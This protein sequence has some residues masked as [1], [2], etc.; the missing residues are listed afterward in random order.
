MRLSLFRIWLLPVVFVLAMG[1]SKDVPSDFF[2][3]DES[4]LHLEIG[5]NLSPLRSDP[6]D[7]MQKILS[8]SIAFFDANTGK[9]EFLKELSP[10]ELPSVTV[11]IPKGRYKVVAIANPVPKYEAMLTLGS[12]L[13]ALT[14]EPMSGVTVDKLAYTDKKDISRLL[15]IPMLNDQG[16][17]EVLP[18]QFVQTREGTGEQTVNIRLEPV[19]ARVVVYGKPQI[20]GGS[21]KEDGSEYRSC[22]MISGLYKKIYP[23]RMPDKL[24]GGETKEEAGDQ[25]DPQRRYARCPGFD[26]GSMEGAPLSD[27]FGFIPTESMAKG[28]Y[29]PDVQPDLS[30][31]FDLSLLA[32]SRESTMKPDA[33]FRGG[34]PFALIRYHYLPASLSFTPGGDY[35]W[36]GFGSRCMLLSEFKS[37]VEKVEKGKSIP[38]PGLAEAIRKV[39][40]SREFDYTCAF[41]QEG[42]RYYHKAANYYLVYIRHFGDEQAP[43]KRSYGRYGIVRNNEYRIKVNKIS[44]PGMAVVPNLAGN[45]S[46]LDEGSFVGMKMTVNAT[47]IREQEVSF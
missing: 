10:A 42:I 35:S 1:C 22:Y 21:I 20:E 19:L 46:R 38:V 8:L 18:E 7:P 28:L 4:Y 40:A 34:T 45:A 36:V 23:M 33:Y 9:L 12:P 47:N 13:S 25:S 30:K 16:P 17:V 31:R 32:Y 27:S 3:E 43:G 29:A 2:Y 14:S 41:E 6:E 37:Y 15:A 26:D 24:D 44:G 5:S 11:A 39:R